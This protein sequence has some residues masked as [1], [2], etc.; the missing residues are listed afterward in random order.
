MRLKAAEQT[1]AV[2]LSDKERCYVLLAS[3]IMPSVT[4]G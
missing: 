1:V 4:V 2:A 3:T